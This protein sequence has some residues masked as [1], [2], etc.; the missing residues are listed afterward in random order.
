MK[1]I[2]KDF[3]VDKNSEEGILTKARKEPRKGNPIKLTFIVLNIN[4]SSLEIRE[5]TVPMEFNKSLEC[6]EFK[7]SSSNLK[8]FVDRMDNYTIP[9]CV[10]QV[11]LVML[12]SKGKGLIKH[13]VSD[14]ESDNED[15]DEDHV[16]SED[17]D[18]SRQDESLKVS[19]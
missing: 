12:N 3:D 2:Y 6:L 19:L 8:S 17:E 5:G 14:G 9:H 18:D 16:G 7:I 4:M 1:V 11:S 13:A 10:K 15:V